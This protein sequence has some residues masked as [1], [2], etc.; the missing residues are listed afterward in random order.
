MWNEAHTESFKPTRGLRQGDP[1]SPYLF[2]I[3]MEKLSLHIQ[4][5]VEDKQWQPITMAKNGPGLSHFLFA[6]DVFLFCKT[7]M[8]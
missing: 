7:N 1:L 3:Y 2:V 6:D 8:T 5:M 4:Q